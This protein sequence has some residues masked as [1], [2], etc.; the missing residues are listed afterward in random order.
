MKDEEWQGVLGE[1]REPV[2]DGTT[3]ERV[4]SDRDALL[5]GKHDRDYEVDGPHGKDFRAK[6]MGGLTKWLEGVG[7]FALDSLLDPLLNQHR[8]AATVMKEEYYV[9]HHDGIYHIR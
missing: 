8:K 6:E 7:P 4:M 1:T 5:R 9:G 3:G 2:F